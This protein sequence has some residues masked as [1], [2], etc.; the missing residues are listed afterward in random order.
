MRSSVEAVD[1]RVNNKRC[2][3]LSLLDEN[4][5]KF[6]KLQKLHF[7]LIYDND[8]DYIFATT[9]PKKVRLLENKVWSNYLQGVSGNN[10]KYCATHWLCSSLTD[11]G[12]EIFL[13]IRFASA[14]ILTIV[15]YIVL[16]SMVAFTINIC[17]ALFYDKLNKINFFDK[18]F[19]IEA[20]DGHAEK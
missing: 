10:R 1:F 20:N 4:Q 19:K 12:W 5:D 17:S 6:L 13:K 7:F 15:W 8:E 16:I 3:N 2:L 18:L 14:N 11:E 9:K